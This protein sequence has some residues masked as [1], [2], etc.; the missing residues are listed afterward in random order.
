MPDVSCPV[1]QVR[2]SRG[3]PMHIDAVRQYL[4]ETAFMPLDRRAAALAALNIDLL[5]ARTYLPAVRSFERLWMRCEEEEQQQ[6]QQPRL[7][8]PPRPFSGNA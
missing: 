5:R 2:A 1:F 6:Q 3:P 7:I 4:K 8:G